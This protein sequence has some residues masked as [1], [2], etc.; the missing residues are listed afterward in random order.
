[1]TTGTRISTVLA[2]VGVVG[3]LFA[4]TAG[5]ASTA[6][7]GVSKLSLVKCGH[8]GRVTKKM[9]T[10][11][12][13]AGSAAS[14]GGYHWDSIGCLRSDRLPYHPEGRACDLAYG[15]I[16]RAATGGNKTDGD[17]MAKWL[18]KHHTK[19][20]IDHVIWRGI[21]YSPNGQWRGHKDKNC[22]SRASVTTCHKDHVHVA[23]KR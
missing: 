18:V 17:K 8:A 3:T 2:A 19:Y 22:T 21:I 12:K 1:M 11:Y 20:A 5:A 13:A 15:K 7:A 9:C 16:G 6:G 4:G 10:L 14:S 23:V